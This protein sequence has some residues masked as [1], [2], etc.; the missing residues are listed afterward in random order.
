MSENQP[1]P[2][3]ISCGN[4]TTAVIWASPAH[5]FYRCL[6]CGLVFLHPL[7]SFE[8]A[9]SWY[10]E[11]Y[12]QKYYSVRYEIQKSGFVRYLRGLPEGKILDVGCGLGSFLD[13]ARERG[14]D[15][16]GV[17][18]AGGAREALS[19]RFGRRI[20]F[21]T[22]ETVPFSRESFDYITFWDTL[23]HIL[24]PDSALKKARELIKPGGNLLVKVPYR[25]HWLVRVA[26]WINPLVDTSG[27]MH[28]PA[29]F[30]HFTPQSLGRLL[31]NCG[32]AAQTFAWVPETPGSRHSR[33]PLKNFLMKS[34]YVI[35]SLSGRSE[36]MF[37]TSSTED[38]L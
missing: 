27:V 14:F 16:Y 2:V 3:C 26:G 31:E 15:P 35:I 9:L 10:D 4:E 17:E 34:V 8:Q 20:H 13:A 7:P 38:T 12:F 32:W 25:P 11:D 22:I 19:Q 24:R 28:L 37:I 29:Q 23:G 18:P 6:D 21:G 1:A 36:S 33:S 5:R 30:Y